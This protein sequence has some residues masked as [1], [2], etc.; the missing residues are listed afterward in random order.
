MNQTKT[1][2]NWSGKLIDL[3]LWYELTLVCMLI[4]YAGTYLG[5]MYRGT[6]S[7]PP[8]GVFWLATFGYAVLLFVP[9]LLLL[10]YVES[11]YIE[12]PPGMALTN[13]TYIGLILGLLH[14]VIA[15][16]FTEFGPLPWQWVSWWSVIPVLNVVV[17][18]LFLIDLPHGLRRQ[19][20]VEQRRRIMYT[21]AWL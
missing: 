5:D 9:I 4:P 12:T 15:T 7:W 11:V 10:T 21:S 17:F 18:V 8:D 6:W 13:C 20:V 14:G 19:A 16:P 3:A 1:T 2:N